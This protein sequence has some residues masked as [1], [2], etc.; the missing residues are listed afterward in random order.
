MNEKVY[1]NECSRCGM[2]CL[3]TPCKIALESVHNAIKN[4]PC[5]ML[6]ID[7][8]IA[9]CK[10][11]IEMCKIYDAKSLAI[12]FGF[13]TGCCIKARAIN[14]STGIQFDYAS[15]S[16]QQKQNIVARIRSK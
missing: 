4:E 6:H 5:P 12:L 2:C 1:P 11:Y 7:D 8:G 10:L 3:S 14:S 13:D 9:T 16:P 15:L